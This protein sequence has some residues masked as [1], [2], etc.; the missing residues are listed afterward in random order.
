[1][2]N[3][4]FALLPA[5]LLA[6]CGGG[7]EGQAVQAC[8]QAIVERMAGRNHAIDARDMRANVVAAEDNQFLI[9]SRIVFDQGLPNEYTQTFDC[10]ARVLDGQASVTFLQFQW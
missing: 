2:R 3:L 7:A 1:M 4:A 6:G 8:Q 5:L 10:R 9:R